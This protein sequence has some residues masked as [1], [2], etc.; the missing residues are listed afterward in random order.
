MK[1]LQSILLS[2]VLVVS[3]ILLA[4]CGSYPQLETDAKLDMS[5]KY[6]ASSDTDLENSLGGLEELN[7][8]KKGYHLTFSQENEAGEIYINNYAKLNERGGI[9]EFAGKTIEKYISKDGYKFQL[10]YETYVKGGRIYVQMIAKAKAVLNGKDVILKKQITY[11]APFNNE[12]IVDEDNLTVYN[13]LYLDDQAASEAYFFMDMFTKSILEDAY[14]ITKTVNGTTSKF[15]T[16]VDYSKVD[17]TTTSLSKLTDNIIVTNKVITGFEYASNL[18]FGMTDSLGGM[19]VD[20]NG[21]KVAY[22]EFDDEIEFDEGIDKYSTILPNLME[23]NSVYDDFMAKIESEYEDLSF[24][25]DFNFDFDFD[26]GG[27]GD[28]GNNWSD[29][30][31]VEISD[32][33]L[34]NYLGTGD[35]PKIS[36]GSKVYNVSSVLDSSMF[37]IEMKDSLS[38][39]VIYN[40]NKVVGAKVTGV[41]KIGVGSNH[42]TITNYTDV[43]DGMVYVKIVATGKY[44]SQTL[45]ET[46]TYKCS[47]EEFLELIDND[48]FDEDYSY[49]YLSY[50]GLIE[51][52]LESLYATIDSFEYVNVEDYCLLKEDTSSGAIYKLLYEEDFATTKEKFTIVSNILNKYQLEVE[53]DFG[54]TEVLI[55]QTSNTNILAGNYST[56]STTLP[57][58]T[59]IDNFASLI[60]ESME[61]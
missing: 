3:A 9:R 50:Q 14:S 36:F 10:Q 56:Y 35:E 53:S 20:L 51:L 1:K 58:F 48:M 57:D 43:I 15:K 18:K 25:F 47:V 5:G 13:G 24:G 4:A 16:T 40:N 8:S 42:L 2:C 12:F 29:E 7:L 26:F 6:V 46:H 22:V 27:D 34:I 32:T 19:S 52:E 21:L 39:T 38:G 33:E 28:G 45:N 30:S 11:Q 49:L 37:G 44:E 55:E 41:S 61:F 17:K 23:V 60:G 31:G 59:N 54:N